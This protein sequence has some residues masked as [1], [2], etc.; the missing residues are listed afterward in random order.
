MKV[1]KMKKTILMVA[2]LV[3]AVS[4][5]ER[6]LKPGIDAF[7]ASVPADSTET[8]MFSPFSFELDC[9]MFGEAL[10]PVGRANVSERLSVMTDFNGA[11]HPILDDFDEMALSNRLFFTSARTIGLYEIGK[12]NADFKRRV[13]DMRFNASISL[14]WPPRG[15]ERWF[16]AKMDGWM[17]DFVMPTGRL[18]LSGYSIVDAAVVLAT[19]LEDA[20]C[21]AS[22]GN[23]RPAKGDAKKMPFLKFRAKVDF[24]RNAE[25]TMVRIPLRGG[26]FLYLAMPGEKTSLEALRRSI[27]GDTIH[28]ITLEPI[29]PGVKGIGTD[30]CEISVPKFDLITTTDM[31]KGFAALGIQEKD[32][33]YL[34]PQLVRRSSFQSVRFILDKGEVPDG[35]KVLPAAN[36]K[37]VFN[38]PFVFF[39]YYPDKNVIPVIG[40]FTGE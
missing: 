28:N 13:F 16:R 19:L 7:N 21:T 17:E 9:C 24:V 38:R 23:F 29:D 30:V 8:M 6:S 3:A 33:T 18:G 39:V 20:D 15:A 2:A 27:T 36:M 11:Y 32:V 4:F 12:V 14:A 35:V 34:Y 5:G 22:E 31:E 26:A 10:D 25:K 37:A 1:F 40:Q